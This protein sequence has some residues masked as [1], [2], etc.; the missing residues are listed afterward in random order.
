MQTETRTD[1]DLRV[2][3]AARR[4]LCFGDRANRDRAAR[5]CPGWRKSSVR[6]QLLDLHYV[7]DSTDRTDRG[8]YNQ[9]AFWSVLYLLDPPSRQ[10]S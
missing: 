2:L 1:D 4:G 9:K 5:L 3:V 10:G 7:D 6:N 8:L